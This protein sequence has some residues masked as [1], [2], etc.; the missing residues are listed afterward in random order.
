M[1]TNKEIS[2]EKNRKGDF[3]TSQ[4]SCEIDGKRFCIIRH[5]EGDKDLRTLMMELAFSRADREMCL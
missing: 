5:F 3:P 4:R 1:K 2:I